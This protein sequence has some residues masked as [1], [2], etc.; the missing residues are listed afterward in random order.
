[1]KIWQMLMLNY[2][3]TILLSINEIF[4]W[5]L[6]T[7]LSNFIFE[8]ITIWGVFTGI[9]SILGYLIFI[10][11]LG[12]IIIYLIKNFLNLSNQFI[13]KVQQYFRVFRIFTMLFI[14]L[15]FILIYDLLFYCLC[16]STVI[17]LGFAFYRY[18]SAFAA[19]STKMNLFLIIISDINSD[20]NT[21]IV[22]PDHNIIQTTNFNIVQ[23]KFEFYLSNEKIQEISDKFG[24]DIINNPII[25]E[26]AKQIVET[27]V[28][29]LIKSSE[30][31]SIFLEILNSFNA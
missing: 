8:G 23:R 24:P 1:M 31:N 25:G 2:L 16:I 19:I 14:L 10:I 5:V 28:M 30:M 29:P 17:L 4:H 27:H 26:N 7:F 21:L 13:K 3:T 12:S 22:Y 15:K 18:R 9:A 20:I 6:T 11:R